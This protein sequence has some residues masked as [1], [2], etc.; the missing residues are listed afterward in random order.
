MRH[1]DD[2]QNVLTKRFDPEIRSQVHA[3]WDTPHP[4][5]VACASI[6]AARKAKVDWIAG[7]TY[8]TADGGTARRSAS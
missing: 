2:I 5:A 3:A 8:T 6:E 7:S 4:R 1:N